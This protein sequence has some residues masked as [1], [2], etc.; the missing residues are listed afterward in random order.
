MAGL[1]L[2]D[3]SVAGAFAGGKCRLQGAG[4]AQGG[5]SR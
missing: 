2:P 4:M 1:W 3:G 5:L